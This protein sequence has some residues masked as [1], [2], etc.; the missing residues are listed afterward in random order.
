MK[1]HVYIII[2]SVLIISCY[3]FEHEIFRWP[4][5]K[6][7]HAN[8]LIKLKNKAVHHIKK[9]KRPIVKGL[10][11]LT[12]HVFEFKKGIFEKAEKALKEKPHRKGLSKFK[13]HLKSHYIR[14]TSPSGKHGFFRILQDHPKIH[15]FGLPLTPTSNVVN[16][17]YG[18]PPVSYGAPQMKS[19]F[20]MINSGNQ[21]SSFN[22]PSSSYS[23]LNPQP[24]NN[25][26]NNN[27]NQNSQYQSINAPLSAAMSMGH[28]LT[29]D[30]VILVGGN[31]AGKASSANGP[32]NGKWK[33]VF[34][35]SQTLPLAQ[36]FPGLSVSTAG[37]SKPTPSTGNVLSANSQ[38]A[39]TS[40]GDI[41]FVDDSQKNNNFAK[42]MNNNNRQQNTRN[43]V[44]YRNS[45][46]NP[47]V[48]N[49][50]RAK[51]STI[52][53]LDDNNERAHMQN[54]ELALSHLVD[55]TI[56][57]DNVRHNMVPV[58][59][60]TT[61]N[62]NVRRSPVLNSSPNRR[63]KSLQQTSGSKNFAALMKDLGLNVMMDLIRKANLEAMLTTQGDYY[64]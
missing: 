40:T 36:H 17:G 15:T 3:G 47:Q 24:V 18:A 35:P 50:R 43:S 57:P 37:K 58:N 12:N 19:Q 20:Q 64:P 63:A 45:T 62:K 27:R 1:I 4:T 28:L 14:Q 5:Y 41:L 32:L 6:F 8:S 30:E 56:N 21:F 52:L 33:P 38:P 26:N 48:L 11:E 49:I 53:F 42:A 9:I 10:H 39:A 61:P 59:M 46:I 25:N 23:S 44:S 51:P 54:A 60:L 34:R 16:S 22:Q 13:Q 55:D 31:S 2:I 29:E 7:Y